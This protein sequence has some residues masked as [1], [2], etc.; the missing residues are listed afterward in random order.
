MDTAI[1]EL[2][3][4][5]NRLVEFHNN[6]MEMWRKENPAN[7]EMELAVLKT[8]LRDCTIDGADLKNNTITVKL[9]ASNS[10]KGIKLGAKAKILFYNESNQTSS[11]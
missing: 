11:L 10:I 2:Q 6:A 1:T 9:D 4:K 8:L 3:A 5:Y 7:I